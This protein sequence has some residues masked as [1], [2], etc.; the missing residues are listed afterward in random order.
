MMGKLSGASRCLLPS[1][2]QASSLWPSCPPLTLPKVKEPF[3]LQ[4]LW[5][6]LQPEHL[7]YFPAPIPAK[8]HILF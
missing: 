1:L 2:L 5:F 4:A 3:T 6:F 7:L 8:A